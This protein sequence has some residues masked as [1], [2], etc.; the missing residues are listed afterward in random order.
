M[1]AGTTQGLDGAVFNIYRDGQI[2]SSDVTKNGGIIE[3]KD[4]TKGLWTF[5]EV[6][7]PEGYALDSTP[8]SV[9]VDVTDGDKQYTVTASNS[10][11]P[12]L[13]ITKADAQ[14]FAKVKAAFLVESLTGSYSTTVTVDGEKT[15]PDLQ[16]GVYRVTEQSVEG[17][18]Y[19]DR[20]PSG[21]RPAGR[22]RYC[23]GRLHQLCKTRFGDP[24]EK[25]C[26]RGTHCPCGLQ[27]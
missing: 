25:H 3:V 13:K 17:A 2:V 19:Q 21:H 15:L 12:S 18:V 9:Y 5:V 6:E 14:T 1:I 23:G 10:P 26:H 27:N 11:L 24:E 4:V 16:P 7:A 22:C 20:H 8:H